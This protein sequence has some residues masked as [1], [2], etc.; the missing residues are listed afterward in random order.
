MDKR[1]A[2]MTMVMLV[3][4]IVGP[5]AV[6]QG[7]PSLVGWWKFDGDALDASGNNRTGTLVGDAG[8]VPGLLGQA[9]VLDGTGDYVNITGYKGVLGTNAFSIALWVN[10]KYGG[11][12]VNWGTQAGGQRVDFRLD[13]GRLRVEHGSG[14]LQ[15]KT[16]LNDGQWHHVVM[17]VAANSSL[18]YPSV[19]FYLDGKDDSQTTTD[20]DMFNITANVDVTIGRRQTNTDRILAGMLDDVRIYDRVL[21]AAEIQTLALRPRAYR[22][23]PAD[24]AEGVAV[25][26]FTWQP[27]QTALWHDVYLSTNPELGPTDLVAQRIRTPSYYHAAGLTPGAVYYWKVDE[28]E[29]DGTI[30][31][32]DVWT[33]TF[34]SKEA[35]KPAPGDGEPYTDP[36]LTLGW[37][38]G[39]NAVTHDVYFGT[40]KAAVTEGAGDAFKGNQPLMSYATGLLPPSTTYYWRVDEVNAVGG[41]IKGPVWTF[42][43]LPIIPVGD[44]NLVGWWTFDEGRGTRGVDWSGHGH[45]AGFT[46]SAQSA[47][48]YNGTALA[49]SGAGQYLEA[50]GYPGVLGKHDRTVAAWIRTTE[51][52]DIMAWGSQTNTQKWNFRVQSENGTVGA[53]RLEVGGGRIVGWMDLRDGEW[54][55]VAAVLQ[56][57][58]APTT[59]DIKLYVDG[60]Q[61]AI[62]DSLTMDVDTVGGGRSVRIGDGHQ[63]R[64]FQGLIDDV[65]IYDKALTQKELDLVL[66]IDPLR[67]WS[68]SPVTGSMVDIRIATPLTWSPGDSAAQHDVYFGTDANAVKA[69]DSSDA[70]GIYRGLQ[71]AASYTPFEGIPWGQKYFWRVDEI[72]ADKTVAKGKVWSFTVV[73]YLIVDNF[74]GYTNNSP[75]RVFQTWIDG[76]GFSSDQYFPNGNLGNGTGSVVGYDPTAGNIMERTNVYSGSQAMPMD[77]NNI[78]SPY[79]SEAERTWAATQNWTLNDVN[80]LMLHFRGIP[81][82]FMTTPSG[83]VIMTAAGWDIWNDTALT[84]FD[85]FRYVYKRLTGDGTIIA[86]V[87]SITNTNAWAKGGV[88]IRETL[89]WVSRHASVFITP[90]QGVAFQRRLSTSFAAVSTNQTGIVA[91]RWI[92]LTRTG[93]TFT[94]QH[95]ADGTTW[96]DVVHATNPTSD[97]VVMG[98]SIYIGLALTSHADGVPCTAEFSEIQTT[99]NVSGQWQ[100]AE[101]GV[102]HPGNS[103]GSLYVAVQDSAGK[104][105]VVT[106]PDPNATLQAAWQR[107]TIDLATLKSAGVNMRTV[108]KMFIGVGDRKNP[109]LDG[110]GTLYIDDIRITKGVPVEPNAVP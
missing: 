13:Q 71:N 58:G 85:E 63:N 10:T 33:F 21:T 38:P 109:K 12:M 57:A 91:P 90:G 5:V 56:S 26:A 11:T 81:V 55:H 88:M 100:M 47:E 44:P 74:E 14:N 110:V 40:D 17:T 82:D 43:T 78:K 94:A 39:L 42:T 27:R 101:I 20:P 92:K 79:Y 49:F 70:T 25:P 31:P 68:P 46:G 36:N 60:L 23:D 54:H 41:K 7:D 102:D 62:S 29:L 1:L 108:K 67:A 22:P 103:P 28:I 105:G 53:I 2:M 73:D 93:D 34:A 96:G 4:G 75:D 64:P 76:M 32:G 48:G 104:T 52:G 66:R 72:N 86:R 61:E 84:R 6:G 15:G 99:G 45:H 95:S 77:Y 59:L 87:D 37:Q 80:T 89:D 83:G 30:Y 107:W 3:V 106:H 9:L 65:R 35:W 51:I 19:I 98:G 69:A 24:K 8:F 50:T 97:T 18:S 16:V